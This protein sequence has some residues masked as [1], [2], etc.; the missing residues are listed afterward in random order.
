MSRATS[1]AATQRVRPLSPFEHRLSDIADTWFP[2]SFS[3]GNFDPRRLYEIAA[4]SGDASTDYCGLLW[5]GKFDAMRLLAKP[6]NGALVFDE[7]RS[8]NAGTASHAFC[9]GDNLEV[10]KLLQ[11]AYFGKCKMAFLEPPYNVGG[12]FIYPDGASGGTAHYLGLLDSNS[13]L[14]RQQKTAAPT[15]ANW[16]SM[17]LP[18]LFV[19]RNLLR[20]DGVCFVIVD[21]HEVHA[22]RLLMN[23]VFGESNFVCTFIWEKKYSPAPDA[24]DVGYV[25]ENILCY[26]KTDDFAMAMLPHTA[27]Q[28]ARYKNPDNDPRG[29]WKTGDYTCRWTKAQR[30]TLY[31]A[32]KNPHTGK[33]VWPK[34]SRVWGCSEATHKQR[35]RDNLIWWPPDA[36]VPALKKFLS[37]VEGAKP[38]TFLSH[39]VAGHTDE[40]T[41]ELR[42]QFSDVA[43]TPKPVRLIQHLFHLAGLE[44]G[45]IVLDPFARVG[46]V[47]AAAART[48]A[49]G[50]VDV[51]VV[52]VELPL[53]IES[54]VFPDL[55]SIGIRRAAEAVRQCGAQSGVRVY[56]LRSSG[57]AEWRVSSDASDEELVSALDVA[58]NPVDPSRSQAGLVAEVALQCGCPLDELP[59]KDDERVSVIE[60][61]DVAIAL[62]E[63]LQA[64]DVEE[65]CRNA[66]ST[67]VVRDDAFPSDEKRL[68][69]LSQLRKAGKTVRFL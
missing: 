14:L 12:D 41:T 16:L 52:S 49:S 54:S 55:A 6:A 50:G 37:E 22:L 26:R 4:A 8:L 36:E 39:R 29:V 60:T 10:L 3:E 21:D 27:R 9:V 25:H 7:E 33:K 58:V 32:I 45:D 69:W 38:S 1:Q 68:A 62:V 11:P 31:Y 19:V 30:P 64:R 23:E 28:R 67:V 43:V 44:T 56:E 53:E 63:K 57:I 15:H 59:L 24:P 66:P 5:P 40:A 42:E 35:E 18:R 51:K 13:R 17:M 34:T 48:F 20:D 2:E 65:L 47:A 46:T 61:A